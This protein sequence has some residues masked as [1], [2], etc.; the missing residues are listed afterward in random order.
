VTWHSVRVWLSSPTP[1]AQRTAVL[2]ILFD[3]GSGGVQDTGPSLVTHFPDATVAAVVAS[4][5]ATAV[6]A[7]RVETEAVPDVDWSQQWKHGVGAHRVGRLTVA[8]PWLTG[9]SPPESTIVVD[10]AMAFG[11]GEHPTTRGVLRLMQSVIR[12][13]DTVADLGAGSAVLAI[14]AAKLGAGRVVAI[15]MDGD[16]IGNAEANVARNQV[17][18]RVHVLHGDAN[19][20]LPLVAPVRVVFA[21]I[22]SSVLIELLPAIERTLTSDGEVVLSGILTA[23]RDHLLDVLGAAGWVV[24]AEDSEGEWWTVA[25]A[26]AP[27]ARAR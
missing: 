18:G 22:I 23:E 8:P 5:I 12:S 15:E 7:A 3:H 13:G 20:L 2:A 6:P 1:E 21:N 24:R 17:G 11:T 25:I 10:P 19:A 27:I 9:E 4:A 16:A 26:R 14:A